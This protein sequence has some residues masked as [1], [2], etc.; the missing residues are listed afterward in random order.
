MALPT[1]DNCEMR[2]PL[3]SRL[4]CILWPR[5][6]VFLFQQDCSIILNIQAGRMRTWKSLLLYISPLSAFVLNPGLLLISPSPTKPGD[7]SNTSQLVHGP[8]HTSK[9]LD[10]APLNRSSTH[11]STIQADPQIKWYCADQPETG[12]YAASCEDAAQHMAFIPPGSDESQEMDWYTRPD[13][14][15]V[16][17]PQA[18]VSCKRPA[19]IPKIWQLILITDQALISRR[20][21]PD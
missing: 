12:P 6:H 2:S 13:I 5:P 8:W 3:H 15:D 7:I 18:V 14:G 10:T 16:P 1:C 4:S 11:L 21:L 17:L 20:A 19:P 9:V